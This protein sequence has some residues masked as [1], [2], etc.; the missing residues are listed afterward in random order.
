MLML[1]TMSGGGGKACKG[2]MGSSVIM[3]VDQKT[4]D[5]WENQLEKVGVFL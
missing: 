3:D 2:K 1:G 5:D 4:V